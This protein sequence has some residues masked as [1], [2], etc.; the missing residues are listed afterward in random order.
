MS[1]RRLLAIAAIYWVY[2]T[3]SNILYA[4]SLRVGFSEV[5]DAE[6]FVSDPASR[7]HGHCVSPKCL[8]R[9][10]GANLNPGQD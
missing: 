3:L 10:P 7:G 6:L 4:Q 5:T 2:V 1:F 9:A 8:A